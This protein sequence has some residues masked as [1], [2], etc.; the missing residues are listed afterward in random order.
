LMWGI[1]GYC[2]RVSRP[3]EEHIGLLNARSLNT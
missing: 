2:P 3:E 1:I